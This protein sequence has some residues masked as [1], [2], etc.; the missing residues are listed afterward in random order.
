MS[1]LTPCFLKQRK[2]RGRPPASRSGWR[3]AA[4]CPA[5]GQEL[6]KPLI[7]ART[8]GRLIKLARCYSLLLGESH[9]TRRLFAGM[10]DRIAAL[11]GQDSTMPR[12]LRSAAHTRGEEL[13]GPSKRP[14]R[15]LAL[16]ASRSG[17]AEWLIACATACGALWHML[18]AKTQKRKSRLESHVA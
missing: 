4:R 12:C 10:L 5:A 8:G 6:V 2:S 11:P 15:S 3:S 14:D 9:L 16:L 13:A 7:G 1:M 17:S 18:K